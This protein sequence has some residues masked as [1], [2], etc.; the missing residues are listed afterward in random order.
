MNTPT[1]P[2]TS[3]RSKSSKQ[4]TSAAAMPGIGADV[5]ANGAAVKAAPEANSSPAGLPSSV[6]SG[7]TPPS[8]GDGRSAKAGGQMKISSKV[9]GFRRAGRPWTVEEQTVSAG[10]FSEEQIKAL[11]AEP[12]LKV[13]FVK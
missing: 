8:G 4:N 12:M 13:V 9:D 1:K 5:L 10:D 3:S 2:K 7:A 11:Q 6:D